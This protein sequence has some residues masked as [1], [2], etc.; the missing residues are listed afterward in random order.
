MYVL[1][2]CVLAIKI[3]DVL[4]YIEGATNNPPVLPEGTSIDL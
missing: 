2:F 4:E 1:L 3:D